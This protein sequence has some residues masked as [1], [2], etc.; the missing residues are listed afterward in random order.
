[1]LIHGSELVAVA[2]G[3][4]EYWDYLVDF[5]GST[6]RPQ[7]SEHATPRGMSRASR[8]LLGVGSRSVLRNLR[9]SSVSPLSPRVAWPTSEL[10]SS[11]PP[12]HQNTTSLLR[13]I[14]VDITE[15]VYRE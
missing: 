9:P 1:M 14:G 11:V 5:L 7:K 8:K 4:V 2:Q 6:I 10:G 15:R 12:A 13:E 3:L